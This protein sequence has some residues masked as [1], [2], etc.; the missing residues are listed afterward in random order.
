MMP[1][2]LPTPGPM[3]QQPLGPGPA[4]PPSSNGVSFPQQQQ[5]QSM[6]GPY[7]PPSSGPMGNHPPRPGSS[8]GMNAPFPGGPN[9]NAPGPYGPPHGAPQNEPGMGAP[10]SL[11]P[12]TAP[13]GMPTHGMA[14]PTQT[15]LSGGPRMSSQPQ[16]MPFAAGPASGPNR[17]PL[18]TPG[19]GYPAPTRPG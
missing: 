16:M 3:P 19:M 18:S 12:I 2:K 5:Q 14:G 6:P 7:G 1:G 11:P 4:R 15:T 13:G 10:H 17:P 9:M 8:Q